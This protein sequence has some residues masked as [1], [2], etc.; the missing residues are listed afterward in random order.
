MDKKTVTAKVTTE[1]PGRPDGE[2]KVRRIAI[3]EIISGDLAEVAIRE[4]WAVDQ[5]RGPTVQEWVDAGYKA[6]AYP[7]SGYEAVS[8]QSEVDAA[9]SA[10][11][12]SGAAALGDLKVE[13]LKR[14]AD[15]RK[16]ALGDAKKKE[17]II[18]AIDLHKA[19]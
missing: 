2:M 12:D 13:Q 9:I 5:A 18:A 17:D 11:L 8:S 15:V 10:Q 14:L 19:G 7:P 3:D 1:F 6:H 16:V 4:G